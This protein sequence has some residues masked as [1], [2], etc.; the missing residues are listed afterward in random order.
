M[1]ILSGKKTY[2]G[3]IIAAAPTLLGFFGFSISPT[4]A[5]EGGA[6][7]STLVE[8]VEEIIVAGGAVFA[9]YGRSVTKG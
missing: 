5:V 6:L 3:I 8:N 2:I 7:L 1:S 9:W 4:A